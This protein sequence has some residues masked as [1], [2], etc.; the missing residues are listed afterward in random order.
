MKAAESVAAP[1]A[2]GRVVASVARRPRLL[3]ALAVAAVAGVFVGLQPLSSPWWTGGDADSTYVASG[4]RLFAGKPTKYFDHPGIPLQ[5]AAAAAFTASWA[6]DSH[7][8]SRA[9]AARGWLWNLDSTR[10]YLRTIASVLFV[11]SVLLAF[12][13]IGAVLG[14]AG[15]GVLGGLL[16]LGIPDLIGAASIL[17]P[18][19]LVAAFCVAGVGLLVLFFRRGSPGYFLAAAAVAGYALTVKLP[20][21]GILP[22]LVLAS[23]LAPPAAG[24]GGRL[25]ADLRRGLRGH[26]VAVTA[27]IAAWL[28]V[29]VLLNI[30]AAAPSGSYV[31]DLVAGLAALTTAG[32][33]AWL[34]VRRTRLR[35]IGGLLLL[36]GGAY[37]A[38][39]I[40]PNL[41]YASTPPAMVRW[42]GRDLT[43]QDVTSS[44][45][46]PRLDGLHVLKPWIPLF[47]LALLGLAR[48]LRGRDWTVLLWAVA[49]VATGG[50]ALTQ[51]PN[52]RYFEPAVA[53]TI[54][55][56]LTALRTARARPS[57]AAAAIVGLTL[58]VPIRD[59]VNA[60]RDRGANG[61]RVEALNRWLEARLRPGEV[62]LTRDQSNDSRYFYLVRF[63]AT[64]P[65]PSY[66]FLTATPDGVAY[67]RTNGLRIRYL[68]AAPGESGSALLAS[69][70]L[71]G[72]AQAVVGEPR[73]YRVVSG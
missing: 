10:P 71:P 14:H 65:E 68:I 26:R 35:E 72:R 16:F 7:G 58:V 56:A 47:A 51:F 39:M 70:G 18:D 60:A 37:L 48:G 3:G 54:P 17:R 8:S 20:G 55:V 69:L 44:S 33:L 30:G 40:L 41:F 25:A 6:F 34:A 43:G 11:G 45:T 64:G 32:W 67:A 46:G 31:R 22:A 9:G 73:I 29:L 23:V 49:A 15:W 50:L 63:F 42:I 4:L 19:G 13:V 1:R 61:A 66:R 62:A 57:L 38:G 36:A 27:A 24:W 5:E 2:T 28:A 53:L 21:I 52:P 12:L 59:G